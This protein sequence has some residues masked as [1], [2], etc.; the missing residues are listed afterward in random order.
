MGVRRFGANIAHFLTADFFYGSL[1]NLALSFDPLTQNR[2]DLAGGNPISFREW[3]GHRVIVDDGG[4]AITNPT[5]PTP[6]TPA[7][8]C[9]GLCQDGLG[10]TSQDQQCVSVLGVQIGDCAASGAKQSP[11]SPLL[12][13][14]QDKTSGDIEWFAKVTGAHPKGGWGTMEC[15]VLY[16]GESGVEEMA[17]CGFP[18]FGAAGTISRSGTEKC[19]VGLWTI[20]GTTYRAGQSNSDSARTEVQRCPEPK[21]REIPTIDALQLPIKL[22]IRLPFPLPIL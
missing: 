18:Y 7:D 1:A 17:D 19:Q 20:E 8:R 14:G 3:D 13:I 15:H 5:A 22:P 11:G 16:A 2:Y 10:A 9:G 12:I 21:K 6:L 4:G